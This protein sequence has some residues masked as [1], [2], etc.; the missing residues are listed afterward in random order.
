ML[1]QLESLFPS[2]RWNQDRLN[3]EYDYKIFGIEVDRDVLTAGIDVRVD[4][5]MEDGAFT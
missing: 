1:K 2:I 4:K 5:M 3:P